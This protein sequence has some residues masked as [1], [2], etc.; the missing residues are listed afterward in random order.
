MKNIFK[1]M[2]IALIAGSIM[3]ACNPEEE[4]ETPTYTITT[5]VNSAVMGS[6]NGG[7]TYKEG[8]TCELRAIPNEG[9]RFVQ[10]QDE[11][12]SNPRIITVTKDETYTATFEL[13]TGVMVTFGDVNWT[14]AYVNG[15]L[16]ANAVMIAAGQTNATDYPLINFQFIAGENTP[17]ETGTFNGHPTLTVEGESVS[18]SMGNPYAWYFESGNLELSSGRKTGDWWGKDV[19]LNI[20]ALDADALTCNMVLN[21][22]MAHMSDLFNDQGY[23]I[24]VDLNTAE[25]RDLSVRVVNQQLTAYQGKGIVKNVTYTMPLAK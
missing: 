22:T 11:N 3:V 10:W 5:E 21:A 18:I 20:Q 14:A 25:A 7:G 9:H 24:S 1:L 6:V 2:G 13:E 16:A 12:T 15:Q 17:V 4:E 23:M 8:E 19:T